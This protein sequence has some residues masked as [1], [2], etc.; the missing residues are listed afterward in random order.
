MTMMKNVRLGAIALL[1]I[2]GATSCSRD[3][4]SSNSSMQPAKGSGVDTVAALHAAT[5]LGEVPSWASSAAIASDLACYGD[6]LN[7]KGGSQP[8]GVRRIASG[9]TMAFSGWAVDKSLPAGSSQAPALFVL[10]PRNGDGKALYFQANRN[11]RQDVT[12]AA[13]FAAI[14]PAMAGVTVNAATSGLPLGAY[15]AEVVVGEGSV[16]KKCSLGPS[17]IIEITSG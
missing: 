1:L 6:T 15:Q 9:K 11:E 14:K 8:G 7:G 17:W 4:A 16:G 13:Q 12:A 10:T 2:A 3:T 5:P